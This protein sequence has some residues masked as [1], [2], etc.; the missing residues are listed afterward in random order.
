MCAITSIVS[1]TLIT[2]GCL[3]VRDLRTAFFANGR[4]DLLEAISKVKTL[5]GEPSSYT[6]QA[7]ISNR[8]SPLGVGDSAGPHDISYPFRSIV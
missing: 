4:R 1:K 5:Q 3:S 8:I 7:P 6:Y 2:P